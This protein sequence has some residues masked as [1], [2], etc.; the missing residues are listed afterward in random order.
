ML[1]WAS[2]DANTVTVICGVSFTSPGRLHVQRNVHPA[3]KQETNKY[4]NENYKNIQYIVDSIMFKVLWKMQVAT[5]DANHIVF[6]M[7]W[8]S[9]DAKTLFLQASEGRGM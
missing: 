5:K 2:T 3:K 4:S 6:T 1:I 8:A 9:R 7:I